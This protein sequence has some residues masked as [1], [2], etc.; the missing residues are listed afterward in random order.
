MTEWWYTRCNM[1][2]YASVRWSW[3]HNFIIAYTEF[4]G[5]DEYLSL[6]ND[7]HLSNHSRYAICGRKFIY[8]FVFKKYSF[9]DTSQ[10]TI[11]FMIDCLYYIKTIY[12]YAHTCQ[13]QTTK[14]IT[15][16]SH[17]R[18]NPCNSCRF[19]GKNRQNNSLIDLFFL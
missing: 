6:F 13:P 10:R 16:H 17:L 11:V 19:I 4:G 8:H 14:I 5:S 7:D 15:S 3:I 9:I 2:L 12:N 18:T 1:N